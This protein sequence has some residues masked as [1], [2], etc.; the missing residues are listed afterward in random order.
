MKEAHHVTCQGSGNWGAGLHKASPR[1]AGNGGSGSG[2]MSN[3]DSPED[4][5]ERS[6]S[7]KGGNG[8]NGG[9][10]GGAAAAAAKTKRNARQQDQNKQVRVGALWRLC[11][12]GTVSLRACACLIQGHGVMPGRRGC[13]RGVRVPAH[14]A[15]GGDMTWQVMPS[16]LLSTWAVTPCSFLCG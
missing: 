12:S 7:G 5:G 2:H 3:D 10:R 1:A 15:A 14:V 8:A 13:Y 6:G 16:R 9:K 11:F 4:E